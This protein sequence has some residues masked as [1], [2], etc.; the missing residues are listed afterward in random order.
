MGIIQVMESGAVIKGP[1]D[2]FRY[3]LWGLWN[4]S[5]PPLRFIM[6]N[7]STADHRENDSTIKRCIAFATANGFGGIRVMNM[8][9]FRATDPSELEKAADPVGPE[10]DD[11]LRQGILDCHESGGKIVFGWGNW[12]RV[13][14]AKI[15]DGYYRDGLI[16]D[17]VTDVKSV[18]YCLGQTSRHAPRHPLYVSSMQRL[19]VFKYKEPRV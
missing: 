7:P 11:R 15:S 5:K 12:G 13:R 2:E 18:P 16:Y 4:C 17:M 19:E 6:L 10:N 14:V 3:E 9:A 1:R 8:F